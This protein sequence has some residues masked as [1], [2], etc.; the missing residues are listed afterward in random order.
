MRRTTALVLIAVALGFASQ[1]FAENDI[2]LEMGGDPGV[3]MNIAPGVPLNRGGAAPNIQVIEIP[4]A[5]KKPFGEVKTDLE[6]AV[7]D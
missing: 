2:K 1:A 3:K 4:A 5:E 7:A 6:K